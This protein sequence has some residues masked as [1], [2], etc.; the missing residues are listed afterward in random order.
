[1]LFYFLIIFSCKDKWTIQLLQGEFEMRK[2]IL[3]AN[4]WVELL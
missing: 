3:T 4:K 1:M 2:N